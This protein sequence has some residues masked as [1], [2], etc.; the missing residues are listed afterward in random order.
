MICKKDNQN[1]DQQIVIDFHLS[2]P[3]VCILR[4]DRKKYHLFSEFDK[5]QT[6]VIVYDSSNLESQQKKK[7]NE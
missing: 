7:K 2:M 6:P 3:R 1:L 4:Y 5:T